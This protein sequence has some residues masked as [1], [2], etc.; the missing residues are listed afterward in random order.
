MISIKVLC[1]GE[2]KEGYLV[3]MEKE[4]SKRLSK[5]C[6]L[7][8]ISLKDERLTDNMSQKDMDKIKE[9]EAKKLIDKIKKEKFAY[10]VAL[11]ETG[12]EFSSKGFA[13]KISNISVT[14]ISTIV[15]VI[16][17]SLGLSQTLKQDSQEILSFSQLTFPH[18]LIR[19]FLLEQLFRAFKINS[20]EKYH[21]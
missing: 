15:F 18:Q 9:E 8:I 10:V 21:H 4:Y 12:T 3:D 16:G 5:Y 6:N 7:E 20:N 11:D 14:G 13:E 2:L 19:C 17:G 1:M